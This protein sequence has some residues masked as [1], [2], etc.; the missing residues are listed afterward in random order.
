V[1]KLPFEEVYAMVMEGKIND[2]MTITAILRT[3]LLILENK[4]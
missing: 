2:A 4:L 1:K 3:R